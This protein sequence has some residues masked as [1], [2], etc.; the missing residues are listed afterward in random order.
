MPVSTQRQIGQSRPLDTHLSTEEL[1]PH[2]Q[3]TAR[4]S[5]HSQPC[6][7]RATRTVFTPQYPPR[8][9]RWCSSTGAGRLLNRWRRQTEVGQ[10]HFGHRQDRALGQ[11]G[12]LPR[13][14]RRRKLPDAR[15]VREEDRHQ[16]DLHRGRRRQ[17]HLLR[18]GE[19]PAQ[20]R[21]GHRMRHRL[22]H[23]L[24]GR[25]PHPLRLHAG[26][27]PRE[28]PELQEPGSRVPQTSTSTR[29]A[30]CRFRGRA[31]SPESPGTRTKLPGGL[32]SVSRPVGPVPQGPRRRALR[33]ARH[34][35]LHHAGPRD[36][37]STANGATTQFTAAIDVLQ[38]QVDDGQIRNIKGNS[39]KED[40]QNGD[41]LAAIVGP[42]TSPSSTPRPATTG[43]SPF[44]SKGGT[45]WNDNFVVPI[46]STAQEERRDA[47]QLLL[48]PRGRGAGRGV[49][50]LHPAGGRHQGS[51]DEARPRTG[52]QPA[53]L[54]ERRDARERARLPQP[55]AAPR[56][57]S[58]ARSSRPSCSGPE[59]WHP[60]PSPRAGQTS[61]WSGSRSAFQASPPSNSST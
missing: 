35:G 48:R 19:G 50:E 5:I 25:P 4:R 49:R 13:R 28:H 14:R 12:P 11:L 55:H 26:A 17:Q 27:R 29:A 3:S 47:H 30:R 45:L 36:A 24:D 37:R 16:G 54:P 44:P 34:H 59:P 61:S 58:T 20:A 39:Y 22:P 42:A 6:A 32:T 43:T 46:G 51:D 18:Q 9:G 10:G 31:A 2:G 33:D 38:K 15:G 8:G 7:A 1:H 53:H 40:L 60:G 21:P 23:R 41:T 57:R 56:S 52:R